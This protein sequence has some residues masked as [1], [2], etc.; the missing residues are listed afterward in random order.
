MTTRK[1]TSDPE[2]PFRLAFGVLLMIV[3]AIRLASAIG[4]RRAGERLLP[5]RAAIAR[6]GQPFFL[7]RA[8]MFVALLGI[9]A[10]YAVDAAPLRPARLRLPN[11]LRWMGFGLGLLSL[12][13]WAWSQQTLGRFWSPQLQLRHEHALVTNGPYRWVCHPMYTALTGFSL[14]VALVT[15]NAIFAAMAAV[16][17]PGPVLVRIPQEERMLLESFGE[18][19]RGYLRRT[20]SLLPLLGT[21]SKE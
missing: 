13:L 14:A 9:L 7:A 1:A 21:G 15:S 8:A 10:L 5:D 20:G 11:R 4:V 19:Y 6:E 16:A 18:Q 2:R 17:V 12:A 3:L